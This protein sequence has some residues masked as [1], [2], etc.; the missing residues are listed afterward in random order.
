MRLSNCCCRGTYHH[1]Q[2]YRHLLVLGIPKKT[3]TYMSIHTEIERATFREFVPQNLEIYTLETLYGIPALMQKRDS[4][5]SS[6]RTDPF[7]SDEPDAI[8]TLLPR[9]TL[10]SGCSDRIGDIVDMSPP[11]S[12]L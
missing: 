2:L 8:S 10:L 5:D 12:S 9:N 11:P 4:Y 7:Y 3:N 1:A 6:L